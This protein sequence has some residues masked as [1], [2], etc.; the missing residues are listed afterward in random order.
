VTAVWEE[1]G[2]NE[3]VKDSNEMPVPA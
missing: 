1:I 3:D 2:P